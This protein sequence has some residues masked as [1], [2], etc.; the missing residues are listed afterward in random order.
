[1][2][3]DITV[4]ASP[5][6]QVAFKN[7]A[8]FN[9]CITKI[10]GTIIDVAQN[11]DQVMPICNLIEYSSNYSETTGKLLIYSKD[12]ANN[13]NNNIANTKNFKSFNYK[14]KLLK[15]TVAQPAQNA[16]DGI[17]RKATIAVPLKY[18]SNFWRS[19]EMPLINCKVE[20]KL[21]WTKY[22]VFSAGGT[23]NDVN[24][25]DKTNNIILT[26]KGTKLYD[27]VVTL[28]ARDNQ[29]LS[30]VLSEGF[31]RSVYWNEYKTKRENKNATNEYRYFLESNFV[32]VNRLF[33]LVYAN[34]ASNAKRINARKY[35]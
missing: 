14:A 13:F 22:F 31:E 15:N 35:Y 23:E 28:S 26:I 12:E 18:L 30:K 11:L 6:I 32:G 17:L 10:D 4:T 2:R 19:L 34:E 7:C 1:M 9:K 8:P 3:G 16:A 24:D 21:K 25:N 20:L 29:K 27:A 33:V 5:Q